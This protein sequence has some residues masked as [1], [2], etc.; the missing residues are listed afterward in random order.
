MKTNSI[1]KIFGL[2]VVLGE[3]EKSSKYCKSLFTGVLFLI[4]CFFSCTKP[5]SPVVEIISV[6]TDNTQLVDISKGQKIELET[7]DSSLLYDISRIEFLKEKI[8]VLSREKVSVFDENGKFLFNISS[9]GEGPQEY[10]NLAN[11]FIK[12]EQIHLIDQMSKKILCYDENGNFVS[13]TKIN[14]NNQYPISDLFPLENGKYIGK[15]MFQGDQNLVPVG[16]ILD[17]EYNFV[18][19]IEGRKILSGI[20]KHDNFYQYK[21]RI[22]Y[23]EILNDTIFS[24]EDYQSVI[25]KYFVDFG[26]HSIPKNNGD[27]YD[28]INYSS[29]PENINKIAGFIGN[30]IENDTYLM[31]RFMF[32]K[33]V[34]YVFYDKQRKN[35]RI[36]RFEDS[37]REYYTTPCVCYHNGYIYLTIMSE[38]DLEKNPYL[39]VFEENI[40][41]KI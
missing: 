18:G 33:Q 22:L 28:L 7:T 2:T 17:E 24:I 19:T 20:T 16:C 41:T 5:A 4:L 11:V 26:N 8:I 23:W 21:D 39:I 15:N 36:F 40:F 13:S 25:P 27:I 9:K 10:I 35:A 6:D 30:I 31:F 1:L 38:T 3:T 12:N 37:N 29:Q 34:H 14:E 32:K